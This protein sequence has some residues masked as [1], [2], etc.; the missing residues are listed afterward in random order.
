MKRLHVRWLE[1]A[2]IDLIEVVEFVRKDRPAA[3]RKLGRELLRA[4]SRLS[5][6]PQIGKIVPEL[7]ERG[8]SDYR[9]VLISS[10]RLIYAIRGQS[11]EVFAVIDGRRDL[12]AALF[13]RLV[14]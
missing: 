6:H 13:Q 9:Q 3:A 1:P 5:R 2:S 12:E 8:M 7:Q 10:Y 11:I 14:R 4:A